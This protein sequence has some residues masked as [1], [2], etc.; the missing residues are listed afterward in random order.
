MQN[1]IAKR[2]TFYLLERICQYFDSIKM[3]KDIFLF[4]YKEINIFLTEK[5]ITTYIDQDQEIDVEQL[6]IQL[7]LKY[8]RVAEI[9]TTINGYVVPDGFIF[10]N[11]GITAIVEKETKLGIRTY[12][13]LISNRWLFITAKIYSQY[14]DIF[15]YEV[16][17]VEPATKKSKTELCLADNL[18][19]WNLCVSF[20]MN[21]LAVITEEAYKRELTMFFN[22]FA[23]INLKNIKTKITKPHMGWDKQQNEFFP[24]SEK[25]HFDFTGDNSKY[26]KNTISA[27]KAYGN[28]NHFITKMAEFT[29][30][31]NDADLIISTAF[32]APLLKI[33]GVRSFA[34]NYYGLSGN[35]KSL[36]S[37]FAMACF[38]DPDKIVSAGN[39]TKNVL[40]EKL[41]KFHNLPFYIDEIDQ[42]SFDIYSI[43]NESGRHR[44]DQTG[45]ILESITWRTICF[46]TSEISM[47]QDSN[48][49]GEINRLI[50]IPVNCIPNKLRDSSQLEREEFARDLYNF[51]SKNYGLLGEKY[52]KAVIQNKENI[53]KTYNSIVIALYDNTMQSQ[54]IYMIASC[55]LAS[56]LYKK[57]FFKIDNLNDSINLGKHYLSV[58][59]KKVELDPTLKMLDAI[60]EFYNINQSAFKVNNISPKTNYCF[61]SV[62]NNTIVFILNPLKEYLAK[63]GFRWNDKKELIDRGLIEYKNSMIDGIFNKRIIVPINRQIDYDIEERESII[64][65]N[66][67]ID[68]NKERK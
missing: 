17:S 18:G 39:H 20:V 41:S 12:Y 8:Q 63:N 35:M 54:H 21:S 13:H 43:G 33:I 19:K 45:K 15:Q 27:F 58:G 29:T 49:V 25:I 52:I 56:Y 61:G 65:E 68:I 2:Y 64:E 57:I 50:C 66:K 9:K 59:P 42:E 11:R 37:K 24:Y 60:Y 7:E 62:K 40:I 34:V 5:K 38:G 44:L 6:K 4:G 28:Y 47:A 22:K 10:D 55:C 3:G 1:A 31:N 14:H 53:M 67:V 36:A 16:M 23:I 32:A 46:C 30:K 48:K 26:L 51:I